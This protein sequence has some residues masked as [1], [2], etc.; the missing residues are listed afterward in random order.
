MNRKGGK[1]QPFNPNAPAQGT[2][3]QNSQTLAS[4]EGATLQDLCEKQEKCL[5]DK[6]R[7]YH[8]T[9]AKNFCILALLGKCKRCDRQHADWFQLMKFAENPELQYDGFSM[10]RFVC[11]KPQQSQPDL[12]NNAHRVVN[13]VEIIQQNSGNMVGS[14]VQ[15]KFKQ[16]S[17][18]LGSKKYFGG[19]QPSHE[20]MKAF[21]ELQINQGQVLKDQGPLG[22]WYQDIRDLMAED[23]LCCSICQR[24]VK[25]TIL[26]IMISSRLH[27]NYQTC[28]EQ[29]H[30]ILKDIIAYDK[31]LQE[32]DFINSNQLTQ[33]EFDT[34]KN[35]DRDFNAII[36]KS[37]F[38]NLKRYMKR[39]R[40]LLSQKVG[41]CVIC[42]KKCE[43]NNF[44]NQLYGLN[45]DCCMCNMCYEQF[46]YQLQNHHKK[47][48]N[49]EVFFGL[50]GD[51][52]QR[53][54]GIYNKLIEFQD[55]LQ[56]TNFEKLKSWFEMMKD[57][58]EEAIVK[59]NGCDKEIRNHQK[60]WLEINDIKFYVCSLDCRIKQKEK[61]NK[62]DKLG[63]TKKRVEEN[64]MASNQIAQEEEG[65]EGKRKVQYDINKALEKYL[66]SNPNIAKHKR[67]M[68]NLAML[69][70]VQDLDLV[71]KALMTNEFDILDAR[72]YLVNLYNSKYRDYDYMNLRYSERMKA[73]NYNNNNNNNRQVMS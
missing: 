1:P 54:T 11:K 72:D 3:N 37:P 33:K 9:W 50:G 18:Q 7:K 43:F 21:Q 19:D 24:K 71:A 27:D 38:N 22:A 52:I 41:S 12:G 5:N 8:P 34:Y 14:S 15:Q 73:Y 2:I 44:D 61:V 69:V 39:M 32:Q 45:V 28:S 67:S 29:C 23:I 64:R 57:N 26:N 68:R 16:F 4:P 49:N 40:E 62:L 63:K 17:D 58:A 60:T 30:F 46:V 36:L 42:N 70:G 20:D 6:C 48:G 10:Q 25:S 35:L 65:E 66:E 59:C 55:Y 56:Y 47:L 13:Q 51:N 31:K 53:E